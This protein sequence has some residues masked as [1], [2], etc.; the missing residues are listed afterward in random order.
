MRIVMAMNS[1]ILSVLTAECDCLDRFMGAI[2]L[3]H[4]ILFPFGSLFHSDIDQKGDR[5]LSVGSMD[6][7]QTRPLETLHPVDESEKAQ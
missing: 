6:G 7:Y 3:T 1:P 2:P 5:S 4:H